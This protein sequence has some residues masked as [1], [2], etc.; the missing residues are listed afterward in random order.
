MTT[1][2]R[3]VFLK[4]LQPGKAYSPPSSLPL[5]NASSRLCRSSSRIRPR[6][7]TA[8]NRTSRSGLAAAASSA[9]NAGSPISKSASVASSR[10]ENS[11]LPSCFTS[12]AI[13]PASLTRRTGPCSAAITAFTSRTSASVN[14][15][16]SAEETRN[17][18]DLAIT[19]GEKP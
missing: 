2:R 15:I 9:A 14:S 10:C 5:R 18:A 16:A 1:G 12:T 11:S 3:S 4:R 19:V 8:R 6:I 17:M 7:R 13:W